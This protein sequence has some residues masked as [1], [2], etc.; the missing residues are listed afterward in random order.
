MPNVDKRLDKIEQALFKAFR[1]AD[2]QFFKLLKFEIEKMQFPRI[3]AGDISKL[4]IRQV[5]NTVFKEIG[6]EGLIIELDK[7]FDK[8]EKISTKQLANEIGVG[9]SRLNQESVSALK[10]D[11]LN[12][13]L[14]QFATVTTAQKKSIKKSIFQNCYRSNKGS[15]FINEKN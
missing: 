4:R 13:A 3:T 5:I 7:Q 10:K 14:E 9:F 1:K 15:K 8:I 11:F 2:K 12:Q 6:F